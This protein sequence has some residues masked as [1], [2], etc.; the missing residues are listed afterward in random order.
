MAAQVGDKAPDFT[1]KNSDMEEVN[2]A[3]FQGKSHVVL[4]FVPLAFTSV[5]TAE[6]CEISG[7][8]NAYSGLGAQ[9][10][11]ISVD[12][13]FSLKAWAEKEGIT[14]PLLSDFNREVAAAYGAQ[15]DELLGFKGVAKRSAFVIDKTGTVRYAE[16]SDD[17]KVV[18][19]FAAIKACLEGLN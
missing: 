11:G 7:G 9:V 18:P 6:L 1:L 13:P 19:D 2:L 15:Y 16:V 12:S 4:L 14:V 3:S 8:L 10:L 5:C 17:P